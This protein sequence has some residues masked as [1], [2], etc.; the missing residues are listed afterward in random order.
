MIGLIQGKC[1]RTKCT[2]ICMW[3]I[4]TIHST[5]LN[6]HVH[7]YTP[8]LEVPHIP[9][10]TCVHVVQVLFVRTRVLVLLSSSVVMVCKLQV[11]VVHV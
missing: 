2:H 5:L 8:T 3:Y 10:C 4:Y 11:Q 6:I 1:L 9:V 7:V